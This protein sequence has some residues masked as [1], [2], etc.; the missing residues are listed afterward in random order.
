MKAPTMTAAAAALLA[1]A[2]CGGTPSGGHSRAAGP[3]AQCPGALAA[4]SAVREWA[5]PYA[6]V[7]SRKSLEGAAEAAM[8]DS[9]DSGSEESGLD[10]I[11]AARAGAPPSL[12]A[13]LGSM[14]GDFR[15]FISDLSSDYQDYSAIGSDAAAV[16]SDAAQVRQAC[17]R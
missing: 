6:G 3:P 17:R 1:L 12:S 2:A 14:A 15:A 16:V 11:S 5:E 13:P 4:A 9:S 8:D 10:H 7:T